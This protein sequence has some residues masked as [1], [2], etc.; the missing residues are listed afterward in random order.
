MKRPSKK[1]S[2]L[3]SSAVV[4]ALISGIAAV[5]TAVLP[6]LLRSHDQP[7]A[8]DVKPVEALTG[9]DSVHRLPVARSS[10]PITPMSE[11]GTPRTWKPLRSTVTPLDEI[12]MPWR[13]AS[14]VT[15]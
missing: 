7:T 4:A 9:V 6:W 8:D 15:F 11:P 10:E 1:S 2:V 12:L 5:L 14:P 3:S 13:P